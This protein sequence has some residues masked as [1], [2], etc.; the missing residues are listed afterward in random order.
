M[1]LE[2]RPSTATSTAASSTSAH[3]T[4]L[5]REIEVCA[6]AHVRQTPAARDRP[7]AARPGVRAD[8]KD[9]DVD[10]RGDGEVEDREDEA[11]EERGHVP[12]VRERQR[13]PHRRHHHRHL[14]P[15]PSFRQPPAC[16]G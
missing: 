3:R 2:I 1:K 11:A 14:P 8:L 6:S 7:E 15:T 12:E 5:P 9:L 10:D 4:S 16:V 13:E